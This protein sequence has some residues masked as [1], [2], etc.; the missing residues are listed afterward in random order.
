MPFGFRMQIAAGRSDA[1]FGH[2]ISRLQSFI[3]TVHKLRGNV[4]SFIEIVTRPSIGLVFVASLWVTSGS[5][6]H[7][8]EI[9]ISQL[10]NR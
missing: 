3:S 8:L 5:N 7:E 1:T 4:R 9:I 6:I 2:R 10:E